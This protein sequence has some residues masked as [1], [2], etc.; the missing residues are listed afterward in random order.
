VKNV[1]LHIRLSDS[2]VFAAEK[3]VRLQLPFFQ[4][5]LW[6]QATNNLLQA[7][8]EQLS[9]FLAVRRAHFKQLFMHGSYYINLASTHNVEHRAFKRELELAK[10]LEFT[11]M[12]VHPGSP[13]SGGKKAG[14]ESVAR[15]LNE[16]MIHENEIVV[17]LENSAHGKNTV[18]GDVRDFLT[19][20]TMLDVPEK[21]KFCIDTAHAYVYGYDI[22]QAQGRQNFIALL[23]EAVGIDNIVLLHMNDSFGKCGSRIDRHAVPG[24][25]VIGIDAL[26]AFATDPRMQNVPI[27]LELPEIAEEEE[28]KIVTTLSGW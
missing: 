13:R 7:S 28:K 14:I 9:A 12:I 10:K 15:I 6:S 3:A 27:L 23:E 26:K 25:G 19:I 11:H 4:C 22:A 17:V 18:G 24:Q 5:F 20:R 1:G 21:V 16:V 2:V 8:D